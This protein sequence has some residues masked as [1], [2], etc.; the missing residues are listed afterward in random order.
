[1]YLEVWTIKT[2]LPAHHKEEVVLGH[3]RWSHSSHP[4]AWQ[5]YMTAS[6]ACDWSAASPGSFTH[7]ALLAQSSPQHSGH[8]PDCVR[9]ERSPPW[10]C[11]FDDITLRRSP[12]AARRSTL[13]VPVER[14][15]EQQTAGWHSKTDRPAEDADWRHSVP[16]R[17]HIVTFQ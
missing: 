9:T 14:E 8:T 1:M 17:A 3:R 10:P 12:V 5:P 13:E 11:V 4:V 6:L 15:N 7:N 16:V 2:L